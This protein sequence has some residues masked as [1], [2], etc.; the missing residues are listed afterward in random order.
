MSVHCATDLIDKNGILRINYLIL[1]REYV[2]EKHLLLN[3][4]RF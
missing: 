3:I 4:A 1:K 2:K